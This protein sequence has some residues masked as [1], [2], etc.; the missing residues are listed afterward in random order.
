M[1]KHPLENT[2]PYKPGHRYQYTPAEQEQRCHDAATS[3][4]ALLRMHLEAAEEVMEA[5]EEGDYEKV[6]QLFNSGWLNE[7]TSRAARQALQDSASLLAH[8]RDRLK[9]GY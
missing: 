4:L 2:I 9:G 8:D 1:P 3:Y 6:G 5:V 7:L